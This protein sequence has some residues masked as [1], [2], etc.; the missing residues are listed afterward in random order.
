MTRSEDDGGAEKLSLIFFSLFLLL[1]PLVF[2]ITGAGGGRQPPRRSHEFLPEGRLQPSPPGRSRARAR[3]SALG[4]C[5]CPSLFV[6]CNTF[7]PRRTHAQQSYDDRR[8]A[9]SRQLEPAPGL[10]APRKGPRR[11]GASLR[12]FQFQGRAHDRSTN[13]FGKMVS[14]PPTVACPGLGPPLERYFLDRPTLPPRARSCDT[15]RGILCCPVEQ[16]SD[17]ADATRLEFLR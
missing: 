5:P 2:L 9:R 1:G 11:K 8:A 12:G 6:S 7:L 15:T 10:I 4:L 14:T 3:S 13:L 16:F 17:R